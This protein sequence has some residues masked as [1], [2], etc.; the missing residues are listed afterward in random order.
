MAANQPPGTHVG[1]IYY[2]TTDSKLRVYDGK[3]WVAVGKGSLFIVPEGAKD[4]RYEDLPVVMMAGDS[5]G[6]ALYINGV[7]IPWVDDMRVEYDRGAQ[8]PRCT[9]TFPCQVVNGL[10]DKQKAD[11]AKG[12]RELLA[13]LEA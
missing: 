12:L 9:V 3:Q 6:A 13:S 1:A 4:M 2:N 11:A 7:K 8:F 10:T 5:N